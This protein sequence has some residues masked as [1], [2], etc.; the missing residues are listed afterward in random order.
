MAILRIF[1][2]LVM[3]KGRAIRHSFEKVPFKDPSS[4]GLAK[5]GLR[6]FRKDVKSRF[7]YL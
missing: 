4:S 3:M 7:F 2:F 1:F 6:S 5:I